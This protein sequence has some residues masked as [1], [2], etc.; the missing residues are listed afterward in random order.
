ML[1]LWLI[2]NAYCSMNNFQ[3]TWMGVIANCI[4]T[5]NTWNPSSFSTRRVHTVSS[6][7]PQAT[8]AGWQKKTVSFFSQDYQLLTIRIW[9]PWAWSVQLYDRYFQSLQEHA[10]SDLR[11]CLNTPKGKANYSNFSMS[12]WHSGSTV[13]KQK[14]TSASKLVCYPAALALATE[15]VE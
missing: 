9:H 11:N 4:K 14:H 12:L 1:R 5:A 15:S 10:D 8:S 13:W 3:R 7:L 6:E 2:M